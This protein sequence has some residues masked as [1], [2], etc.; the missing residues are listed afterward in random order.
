M[1]IINSKNFSKLFC[2]FKLV[3]KFIRRSK[4]SRIARTILKK[5]STFRELTLPDF[6]TYYTVKLISCGTGIK[7]NT[8]IN[9][10]EMES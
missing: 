6:K 8:E 5:R 4:G 1:H 9:G 7:I 2:R 3:P 10:T